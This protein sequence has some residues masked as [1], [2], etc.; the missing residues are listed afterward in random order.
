MMLNAFC[1]LFG[2]MYVL[3]FKVSIPIFCQSFNELFVFLILVEEVLH[4]QDFSSPLSDI[5]FKNIFS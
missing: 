1:I 3:F 2:H 4:I 5:W